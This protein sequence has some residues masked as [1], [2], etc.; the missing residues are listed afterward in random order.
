MR[1]A[2]TIIFLTTSNPGDMEPLYILGLVRH[3]S[4]IW[5]DYFQ[6]AQDFMR[7]PR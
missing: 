2:I 4:Q 1:Y 3:N 7:I 5:M 6:Y